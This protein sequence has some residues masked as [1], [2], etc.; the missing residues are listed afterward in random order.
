[1]SSLSKLKA[2]P[3]LST[4]TA[5]GRPAQVAVAVGSM[6]TLAALAL[7]PSGATLAQAPAQNDKNNNQLKFKTAQVR[8]ADQGTQLTLDGVVEAVRFTPIATQVAGAIVELPVKA[9]DVV[10][11]GQLLLRIDARAAQQQAQASR[12]QVEAAQAALTV[13]EKDFARQKLL[14][15]KNYISQAQLD[16]ATAQ[17]NSARAL[18]K[19]QIAQALAT[20]TQTGFYTIHAPYDGVVATMPSSVGEMALPGKTLMSVYDARDLRVMVNVP[21][22]RIVNLK[23]DQSKLIEFPSLPLAQRIV[24]ARAMKIIP[25]SD[26]STHTVQLRFDLPSDAVGLTPGL[27]ARVNVSFDADEK[28]KAARHSSPRLFVPR[29]AVFRRAELFAVYVVNA[30]GKLILRQVKPGPVTGEEQEILSGV[31]AGETIVVDPLQAT[32]SIR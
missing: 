9:G 16:R 15:E 29:S 1:M 22:A 7:A 23:S 31:A 25:V 3:I 13:A 30:Q 6:A 5:W 2:I 32:S 20:E 24:K 18:A 8:A 27:F 19:A 28:M 10:K 4:L 11:K 12:S 21:A 26:P 14:F 17:L